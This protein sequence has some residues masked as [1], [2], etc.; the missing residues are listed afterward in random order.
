MRKLTLT[1]LLIGAAMGC[2]RN[3]KYSASELENIQSKQQSGVEDG[4]R[5]NLKNS[6]AQA[7]EN[8]PDA[9]EKARMKRD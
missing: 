9:G 5:A 7:K 6:A 8:D 3:P 4:E 2:N 1:I